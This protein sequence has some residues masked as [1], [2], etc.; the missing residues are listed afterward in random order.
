M[1]NLTP[2]QV[3]ILKALIEEYIETAEPVGSEKLEKKYNLGVSPATLRN[4]MVKLTQAGFLRQP[5]TSAG[6]IPTSIALKYYIKELMKP[7]EISVA[8][9][10][11]FKEKIWDYRQEFDRLIKET[12]KA[13]AEKTKAL[14]LA[15]TDQ[16]ELYYAGAAN[17]LDM[18]EFYDIDL[19]KTVLSVL[20]EY[21]FW[22]RLFEKVVETEGPI[23][24]LLGDELGE[25]LSPCGFVY[26]HYTFGQRH[27][28]LGVVGPVRLD[29]S[30]IIPVVE[31]FGK[32]INEI[33]VGW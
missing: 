12:T 33:G 17:I 26:T 31:Y 7:K 24:I 6:R 14:G 20:D 25:L 19:T 5:H 1:E 27:G 11:A 28:T 15:T 23:H 9:E 21:S 30:L 3:Q 32:L 10:V 4:E 29:Y 13:L 18:P 16:G 22:Q 2:R 8:D